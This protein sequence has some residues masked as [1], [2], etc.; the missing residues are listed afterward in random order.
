[1]FEA[2]HALVAGNG[3]HRPGRV[4]VHYGE[5]SHPLQR[6]LLNKLRRER[7]FE[8]LA[9]DLE[10]VALLGDLTIQVGT[11]EGSHAALHVDLKKFVVSLERALVDRRPVDE[12]CLHAAAGLG[13]DIARQ[14]GRMLQAA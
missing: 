10:K 11:D 5:P 3:Q 8:S 4:T 13:T 14:V 9:V 6:L 1:M 7:V 2:L 12:A